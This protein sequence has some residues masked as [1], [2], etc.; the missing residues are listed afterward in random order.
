MKDFVYIMYD[1]CYESLKLFGDEDI[2]DRIEYILNNGTE[3][4]EQIN[5]YEKN[6]FKDLKLYLINNVDYLVKE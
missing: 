1:Y 6:G 3:G 4:D 5:I 2:I